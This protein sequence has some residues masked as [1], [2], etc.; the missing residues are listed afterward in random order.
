MADS[1]AMRFSL[2]FTG[3]FTFL[4]VFYVSMCKH[5]MAC[6]ACLVYPPWTC[7][8]MRADLNDRQNEFNGNVLHMRLQH[9]RSRK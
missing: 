3:D 1:S 7:M 6:G 8:M 5:V 4:E 2:E 9:A